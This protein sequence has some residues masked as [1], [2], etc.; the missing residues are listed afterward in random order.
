MLVTQASNCS[1]QTADHS[2]VRQAYHMLEKCSTP[3]TIYNI[4]N[5]LVITNH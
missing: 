4:I 5:R 2:L 3:Q 1:R